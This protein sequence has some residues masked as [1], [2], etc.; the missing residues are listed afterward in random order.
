MLDGFSFTRVLADRGYA[1]AELVVAV[2]EHGSE[3]VNPPHQRA[4]IQRDYDRWLYR[5][6]HLNE[7]CINKLKPFRRLF[8]R[9]DKLDRSFLGFLH[10]VCALIWLR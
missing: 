8:S 9:V 1:A 5:E 6:R 7:C 10:F 2:L 3:A 4:K